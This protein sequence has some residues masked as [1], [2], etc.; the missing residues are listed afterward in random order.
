MIETRQK[1]R[2]I[3]VLVGEYDIVAASWARQNVLL[4]LFLVLDLMKWQSSH[5]DG[6]QSRP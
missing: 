2:Y 3:L 6:I 4:K 5:V 1:K